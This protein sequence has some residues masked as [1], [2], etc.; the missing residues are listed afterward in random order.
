MHTRSRRITRLNQGLRRFSDDEIIIEAPM[1]I[2]V[3]GVP[4]AALMRTPGDDEALALGYCY[5]EGLLQQGEPYSMN[6]CTAADGTMRMLLE[7]QGGPR[8]VQEMMRGRGV[9]MGFSCCGNRNAVSA[10][11]LVRTLPPVP[12]SGPAD[13][14]EAF[15]VAPETLNALLREAEGYQAL[16]SRTGGTHFCALY[17]GQLTMLAFA[18]DTGRH[19][20]LDKAAG[21]ALMQGTAADVHLVL[22]SSRL[23]FEMVQ[24]SLALKARVVAGLSAVTSM[25]T[26]LAEA[27]GITLV[28]FLRS[29]RMNIYTHA[30]RMVAACDGTTPCSGPAESCPLRRPS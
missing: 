1:E 28:G 10:Q 8:R 6:R 30:Q 19:N 7:I 3:N 2:V 22:L 25:G 12:S 14:K 5:T 15:R 17:D 26:E 23:S 24:K 9:R 4:W 18:E 27:S 16:F 29:G 21:Q 11:E 20:A 13:N